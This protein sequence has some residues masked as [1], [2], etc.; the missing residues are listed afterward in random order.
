[1]HLAV[2][3]LTRLQTRAIYADIANTHS[4]YSPVTLSPETVAELNF[5]LTNYNF[6]TGYSFKPQPVTSKILFTDASDE[7]DG[8]YLVFTTSVQR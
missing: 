3:P 4:W 2:G 6:T 1:M 7:G 8:G 5:W